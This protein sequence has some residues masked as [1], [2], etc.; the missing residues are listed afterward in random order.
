[1]IEFCAL[2][3]FQSIYNQISSN[4]SSP[5]HCFTVSPVIKK[6]NIKLHYSFTINFIWLLRY[7]CHIYIWRECYCS[8]PT[9]NGENNILTKKMIWFILKFQKGQRFFW[10]ASECYVPSMM[11]CGPPNI[12]IKNQ[13]ISF[14]W[15]VHFVLTISCL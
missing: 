5:K 8:N 7:S 12:L 3:I 1:M 11:T 13:S 2:N 6:L 4:E 15:C 10:P 14:S 9:H